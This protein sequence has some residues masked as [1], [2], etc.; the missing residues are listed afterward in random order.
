IGE[1]KLI[2][3]IRDNGIPFDPTTYQTE[4]NEFDI[5]G[6]EVIKAIATKITYIRAI[7]LNN[8]VLEFAKQ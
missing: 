5:H 8:T 7:D 4:E 6:I 2:L 3:R 1:D